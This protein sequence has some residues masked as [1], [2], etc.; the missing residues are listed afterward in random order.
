MHMNGRL[1]DPTTARMLSADPLVQDPFN[2]QNYNRYSYV[3]NNPLSY[4]DPTGF[5]FWTKWRRPIIAIVAAVAA[6][7]YVSAAVLADG[8]SLAGSL[9][10]YSELAA[11]V[12]PS[13]NAA[14]AI[15]GGFAAGGIQGGNV[16]SALAGAWFGAVS[17]GIGNLTMTDGGAF[18]LTKATSN[19]AAHAVL[20]CGQQAWA[21]GSCKAGAAAG[22]FSAAA[23]AIPQLRGGG[24]AGG[25]LTHVA[26]G[27]VASK[28]AGGSYQDGAITASF[29]Y[30]FNECAHGVCTSKL[31]QALYDWWPGYKFGT[32]I[33]NSLTGGS[34]QLSEGIDGTF[35]VVGIAG[36]GVGLV[37]Q[38][39]G[40][41]GT[42]VEESG[43]SITGFSGHA[44][45]QA[46]SRG[47]APAAMLD[48]VKN[49]LAVLQQG[50]GN[51]L[52]IREQ[53]AVVLNSAGR[54]VTTYPARLYDS[55]IQSIVSAARALRTGQ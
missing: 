40:K 20:G 51:Y 3:L 52:Q 5:S 16:Q 42:V 11:A 33:Y 50:S 6:Q 39:F 13:A 1:Y 54:V 28:L 24:F 45:D 23:G 15:A 37:G 8:T 17:F 18:S 36:K 55:T 21:G 7:Y 34:F 48:A 30:L 32:G 29:D 53:A 19:V 44:L 43:L 31:E 26:I 2:G 47:V 35:A 22:G 14:G 46:I 27:A 49:P 25:L 41:L 9:G 4:T 10:E 38:T 12:E